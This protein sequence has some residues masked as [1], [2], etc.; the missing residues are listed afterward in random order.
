MPHHPADSPRRVIASALA[1]SVALALV[2]WFCFRLQLNLATTECLYL[3][4]AVVPLAARFGQARGLSAEAVPGEQASFLDTTRD[5]VFSR[6]RD[7][8]ITYWSR[9][10]VEI[11]CSIPHPHSRGHE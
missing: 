1:G 5:T 2:T 9:G 6:V 10:A 4:V 7:D 3:T 11:S 8:A